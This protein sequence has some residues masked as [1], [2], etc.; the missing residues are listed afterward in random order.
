ME[1]G[2]RFGVSSPIA[3]VVEHG[4]S[5]SMAHDTEH[6]PELV[7]MSICVFNARVWQPDTLCDRNYQRSVWQTA[8]SHL[9]RLR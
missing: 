2:V 9:P 8:I 7:D 4:T 5:W 1:H 3:L 6:P